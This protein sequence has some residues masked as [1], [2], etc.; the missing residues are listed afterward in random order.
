MAN[1]CHVKVLA[2][3]WAAVKPQVQA[4][5]FKHMIQFYVKWFTYIFVKN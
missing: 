4:R 5:L 2:L 1:G 3:S